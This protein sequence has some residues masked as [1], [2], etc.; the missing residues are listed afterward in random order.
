MNKSI[1]ARRLYVVD[2]LAHEASLNLPAE[3]AHYV[4]NVLRM[5]VGD[6]LAV[7]NGRDGEWQ[8]EVAGIKKG[9]CGL[10]IVERL[11]PQTPDPDLWLAFAPLKR[12]RVD[13]LAEKAGELG[14]ALL[15]PVMTRRTNAD[16][17]NVERLSTI[18]IE[19]AQQCGRLSITSVRAPIAFDRLFNEWPS[20]RRLFVLD[21]SGG[22]RPLAEALTMYIGEAAGFLIGP[23]GGFAPEE[24]AHWRDAKFVTP[25]GL[26]PRLLRAETAAIAAISCWQA[27]AGDWR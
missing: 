14:A 7:F 24:A 27:V 13:W 9:N 3:K 12:A 1:P 11:R 23:E 25:V 22:G 2:D 15:W 16:R 10:R 18:A 26:G 8:A 6:R 20:N 21:E 5:R 17:V 19:A 4:T